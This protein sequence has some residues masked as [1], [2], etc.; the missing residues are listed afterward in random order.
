MTRIV[1]ALCLLGGCVIN[2][3]PHLPGTADDGGLGTA[4]N[5]PDAPGAFANDTAPMRGIDAAALVDRALPGDCTDGAECVERSDAT[6]AEASADA[7]VA[8]DDA[9]G[10]AMRD[11]PGIAAEV[12][13]GTSDN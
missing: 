7:D 5:N 6:G 1:L 12:G 2:T 9:R 3:R 8:P 4:L 11:A 10:D 13:N